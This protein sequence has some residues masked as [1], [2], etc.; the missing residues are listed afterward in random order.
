MSERTILVRGRPLRVRVRP[1]TGSGPPLLLANGIGAAL[2]VLD[3]F[4]DALDPAIEVVRFDAPG[5]GGSPDPPAPLPYCVLARMMG[6]LLDELGHDRADVLGISWGG[7]LAQQFAFQ[8]P[9]RCR[10]LVLVATATGAL[11]VPGRPAVL[12]RMLTPRRHRDA[13]YAR[14][15]AGLI[16]G[17]SLRDGRADPLPIA[18]NPHASARGYL[19]QLLSTAGWTSLPFLPLVR[20]PTLIL[21]GDDDPIVPLVNARIMARLLPDAR[22]EVYPDGHLGLLVRARELAGTVGEFLV[23]PTR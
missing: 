3:P 18:P 19:Y 5:V 8:N 13:G 16:Y 22:L 6:G 4:V 2:E 21:A 7:G 9:R 10:R 1:G 12:A 23:A 15:V 17:G 20:Q 14:R 11:M